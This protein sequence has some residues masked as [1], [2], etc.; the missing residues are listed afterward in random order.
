MFF[1]DVF[2]NFLWHNSLFGAYYFSSKNIG[3]KG[4]PNCVVVVFSEGTSHFQNLKVVYLLSV[5]THLQTLLHAVTFIV[6]WAKHRNLISIRSEVILDLSLVLFWWLNWRICFKVYYYW[7]AYTSLRPQTRLNISNFF[8]KLSRSCPWKYAK[9]LIVFKNLQWLS[10]IFFE[11]NIVAYVLLFEQSH[12]DNILEVVTLDVFLFLFLI[13]LYVLVNWCS[14][15][16]QCVRAGLVCGLARLG[17]TKFC[18]RFELQLLSVYLWKSPIEIFFS[19]SNY[20]LELLAYFGILQLCSLNRSQTPVLVA[21]YHQF[22]L[23]LIEDD[24]IREHQLTT[25]E[26]FWHRWQ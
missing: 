23:A 11:N 21:L 16:C 1:V 18:N 3:C 6:T 9:K 25:F 2:D 8:P 24:C 17:F 20:I 5:V 15:C 22:L 26:L 7:L 13:W 10:R 19:L 12:C 14:R 4:K